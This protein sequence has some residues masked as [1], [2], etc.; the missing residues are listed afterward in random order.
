[1][2]LECDQCSAIVD[3]QVLKEHWFHHPSGDTYVYSFAVCPRCE[4]PFIA[5]Q[6][7]DFDNSRSAPR[8]LYPVSELAS[9]S[10][11]PAAIRPSFEEATRCYRAKAFTATAVMCRKTLEAIC[12]AHGVEERGLAGSLRVLKEREVIDSRLYEWA[13]ALRLFGNDAAHDINVTIE[14]PDAKDILDFT[15]ALVEY[16]F[17]FRER[18]EEFKKRRA[19]NSR[20]DR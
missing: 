15:R 10:T 18:F 8:R 17:T 14:G 12:H 9:S 1:M 19:L 6:E 11:L 7:Q 3:A 13:D 4:G 20:G 2:V 5:I 16:V